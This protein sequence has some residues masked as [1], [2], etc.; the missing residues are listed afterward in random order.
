VRVAAAGDLIVLLLLLLAL[1]AEL[2]GD[3]ET[4]VLGLRISLKST[5]RILAWAAAVG[6]VRHVIVPRPAMLDR[7]WDVRAPEVAEAGLELARPGTRVRTVVAV[8]VAYTAVTVILLL[9]QALRMD[10]VPDH[11]DPLFSV[12]RLAWVAHQLPRDP[13]RVYDANIF[14]PHTLTLA[15]SD[16]M[17]V[18]AAAVAPLFWLGVHQLVVYNIAL[19]AAIV[20]SAT[21]ACFLVYRLTGSLSAGWIAGMLFGFSLFRFLHYSHFELQ[22]AH[23]M[24]LALLA[25]HDLVRTQR[26]RFGVWAGVAI[27]LQALSSLYY[28]IF[29][30]LFLCVVAI[31]LWMVGSIRLKGVYKPLLL[32]AAISAAIVIPLTAPYWQNRARVGERPATAVAHYSAVPADFLAAPLRSRYH[33]YGTRAEN[34]ERELF[35]GLVPVI[36]AAVALWP[37]LSRM[38]F[39]YGI[40][41]VFAVDAALGLNGEV[42]HWLYDY[43][44]G[45][46][47]LRVP[48]RFGIIVSLALSVLAGFGVWRIVQ[49]LRLRQ[50]RFAFIGVCTAAIAFE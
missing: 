17:L 8:V 25:F 21:T 49:A 5:W 43:V 42:Y 15:F 6:I 18:P 16:A 30:V 35:P 28:G 32:G 12:W 26:T 38:R 3:F 46:R 4:T 45:V 36:L 20:L 44:P 33:E 10:G 29:F 34:G 48:A 41:L 27:A 31:A 7:I 24:P 22:V 19:F 9:P 23:W 14:Y 11:G 1:F 47:G 37:P 2:A 50:V 39:A 40:G 13:L